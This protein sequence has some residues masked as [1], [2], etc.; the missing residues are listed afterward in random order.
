MINMGQQEIINNI[1]GKLDALSKLLLL[2]PYNSQ[3][4]FQGKLQP[5]SY[6]SIQAVQVICPHTAECETTSCNP[7]SLLQNAQL[8]D[9]PRITQLKGTTIHEN[10]QVLTGY[11]PTCQTIY[12]ADHECVQADNGKTRVYLND[13]K[14]LR[15]TEYFQTQ[16]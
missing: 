1:S 14:Y 5:V 7:Q 9:I 15:L 13:A 8:R 4:Q 2:Y 6:K 10:V 12:L 11:C 16:F 3:G